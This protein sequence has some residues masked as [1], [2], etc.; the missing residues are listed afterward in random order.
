MQLAQLINVG[1]PE[2][3]RPT[4][5]WKL[6]NALSIF[7]FY[8][9]LD[10]QSVDVKPLHISAVGIQ[11]LILCTLTLYALNFSEGI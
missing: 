9:E 5:S 11:L 8:R 4:K 6:S 3:S 1:K 10:D 2:V 7:I